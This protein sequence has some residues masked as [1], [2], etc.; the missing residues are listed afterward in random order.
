MVKLQ[1][2]KEHQVRESLEFNKMHLFSP[3]KSL[4]ITCSSLPTLIECGAEEISH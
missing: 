4:L 1:L 2:F 3:I